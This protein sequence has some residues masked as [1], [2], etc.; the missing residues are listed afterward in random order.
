MY[1]STDLWIN[2]RKMIDLFITFLNVIIWQ[3][4]I[5]IIKY[6]TNNYN[7]IYSYDKKYKMNFENCPKF[8]FL[9]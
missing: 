3:M 1:H 6:S 2:F 5:F 9:C 7:I 8:L 4:T